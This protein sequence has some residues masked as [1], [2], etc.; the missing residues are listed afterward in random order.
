MHCRYIAYGYKDPASYTWLLAYI[1]R[2]IGVVST[3]PKVQDH[4]QV[5]RIMGHMY[6]IM[7]LMFAN[8]SVVIG[9]VGARNKNLWMSTTFTSIICLFLLMHAIGLALSVELH[10][11]E[12]M[13]WK[14]FDHQFTIGKTFNYMAI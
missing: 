7:F 1:A 14:L 12:K 11:T 9:M 4:T 6:L 2:L 3:A 13:I 10:I 8:V 5:S